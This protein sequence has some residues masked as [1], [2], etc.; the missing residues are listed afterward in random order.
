MLVD[1]H[2]HLNF[3]EFSNDL[4]DIIKRAHNLGIETM[5]T[6]NTRL[7]EAHELQ[8]IA[9]TYD[10]IFCSVGVHPHESADYAKP[11]LK[12]EI[13]KLAQH[14]KVIGIGETGLDYFYNN[15]PKGSQIDSF[16]QHL[17]ASIQL[18]LPVIIHTRDADEDTI[19]CLKKYPAAKGVFHCF[20]GAADLARQALELGY[21]ISFSGILTFKKAEELREIAKFVPLDR[22]LVETDSPFLAPIPHRG[23]RN[24]P[25]FTVHTAE[26]LAELKELSFPHLAEATTNNF[27]NLFTK[28]YRAKCVL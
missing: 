4:P 17:D 9:D 21:Y 18:S 12:A 3:P 8:K 14:P 10:N 7:S 15:S 2:C 22:I 13:I 24:E 20:S 25:A 28:A 6:V 5:L 1:S 19:A 16:G 11:G 27:F 23:K 26:L